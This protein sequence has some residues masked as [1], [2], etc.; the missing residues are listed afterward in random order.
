MAGSADSD[1][2]P[3]VRPLISVMG[4]IDQRLADS[5]RRSAAA[6]TCEAKSGHPW[7]GEASPEITVPIARPPIPYSM[8]ARWGRMPER[9]R[10]RSACGVTGEAATFPANESFQ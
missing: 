8:E 4:P 10:A 5:R 9:G 7:V 6:V 1:Q 3:L 2:G